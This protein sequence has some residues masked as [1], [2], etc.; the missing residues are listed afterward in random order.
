M[1]PAMIT[2]IVCVLATV[3]AHRIWNYEEIFAPVRLSLGAKVLIDPAWNG[4]WIA[5]LIAASTLIEHPSV[6][7][8]LAVLAGYPLLR[9]LVTLYD[10]FAPPAVA[11]S[12]CE[13][14]RKVFDAQMKDLRAFHKRVIILG[15][16]LDQ[17]N[18][19]AQKHKD[20]VVI[21]FGAADHMPKLWKNVR[22]HKITPSVLHGELANMVFMG[23]NATVISWNVTHTQPWAQAIEVNKNL[24][25]TAWIHVGRFDS[26][27]VP[28]HHR[29]IAPGEPVDSLI[30]TTQ[31]L[32]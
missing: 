32:P 15:G 11:C 18:W 3:A 6:I 21:L 13:A 20:W 29:V 31:A 9:G 19:I 12:P 4:L 25:G 28:G 26:A 22:Y 27:M 23:G 30:E 7:P 16:D 24:R 17:A 10:H 14:K 5:P 2:L 1:V 8:A